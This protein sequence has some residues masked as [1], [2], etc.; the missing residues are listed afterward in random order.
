MWQAVFML[1]NKALS[2]HT[3]KALLVSIN[4]AIPN[5][6]LVARNAPSAVRATV[7]LNEIRYRI[8]N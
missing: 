3:N 4:T 6:I 2:V 7:S 1:I 5:L 8:K